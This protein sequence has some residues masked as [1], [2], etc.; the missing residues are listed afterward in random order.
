MNI[1]Q[2]K[3]DGLD[4]KHANLNCITILRGKSVQR[5]SECF[6]PLIGIIRWK[7]LLNST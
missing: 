1:I 4:M 3:A 7:Q 6:H 5:D 2:T